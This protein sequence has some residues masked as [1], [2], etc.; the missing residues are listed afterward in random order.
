VFFQYFESVDL[1]LRLIRDGYEM[2]YCPVL[3]CV[4]LRVRGFLPR[5]R[6]PINYLSLRNRLWIV[7]KHYP[8]WRGLCFATGRVGIACFRSVR[9]GWTD[10]FFRGVVEG[11]AAPRA[12]RMQRR[13][14]SKDVWHKIRD[15]RSGLHPVAPPEIL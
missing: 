1:S 12:I 8:L 5:K 3:S 6:T 7:W 9:Y 10:Y 11:I 15:I 4:E 14:L 13:P 2:L